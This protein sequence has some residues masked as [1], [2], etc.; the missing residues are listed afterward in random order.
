[1]VTIGGDVDELRLDVGRYTV[2]FT[3]IIRRL[4]DVTV[5]S[6]ALLLLAIPMLLIGILIRLTSQGPALFRQRRVGLG[7]RTFTMYKFRTMRDGVGDELLRELIAA[8]LRGEN[9]SVDGSYKLNNDPRVTKIGAFL[10]KTSLDEL[11]QLINVI[12]GDMA[13]VGPRPCLEWEARMFP[14]EFRPRFSVRPGMT[15]LWQVSGRSALSTLDMLQLDLAYVRS[16]SLVGD[17]SILA[18]TIPSMLTDHS[19]R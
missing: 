3:S 11:P 13:L 12:R 10:R 1:M 2:S 17:L 19:A 8:E 7:G 4:I 9:P 14:A 16:R 6:I 15:G 18:R 5:A